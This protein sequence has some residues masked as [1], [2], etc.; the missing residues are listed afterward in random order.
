MIKPTFINRSYDLV[1]LNKLL[2]VFP[3]TILTG[4]RQCGKTT[5]AKQ[6]KCLQYLNAFDYNNS[7]K[8]VISQIPEKGKGTIIIDDSEQMIRS[9]DAIKNFVDNN[10]NIK[11]L[12]IV[13]NFNFSNITALP[14]LGRVGIYELKLLT[15]LDVGEKNF[16]KHIIRGGFP[17]SY[18]ETSIENSILWR[19]KYLSSIQSF[20][21]KFTPEINSQYIDYNL[22][23]TSCFNSTYNLMHSI[24]MD[25]NIVLALNDHFFRMNMINSSKK[26]NDTSLAS[27]GK[28]YF[29][30]TGILSAYFGINN[31]S[32]LQ[33]HPIYHQLIETYFFNQL[34][35]IS[36]IFDF[37]ISFLRN[38]NVEIDFFWEKDNK[39]YAVEIK[40]HFNKQMI[41]RYSKLI[42]DLKIS[43]MWLVA[44]IDKEITY[45]KNLSIVPYAFS[46][47]IIAKYYDK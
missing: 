39:K 24:K 12:F 27:S 4:I 10:N 43:K 15:I 5:L 20:S 8:S 3:I 32:Q 16:K 9:L 19:K 44:D 40:S 41:S 37:K 23:N 28:N 11:F 47:S 14:L 2:S 45:S 29:F 25:K 1:K 18:L 35:F 36:S 26:F 31:F 22:K 17:V 34:H 7:F 42:K 30:D 46:I 38:H 21:D 13:D 6:L 33:I